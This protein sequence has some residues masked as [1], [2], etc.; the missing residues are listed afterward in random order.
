MATRCVNI[1]DNSFARTWVRPWL[2]WV[3]C[4]EDRLAV[5]AL[6]PRP[7][8]RRSARSVLS[9]SHDRVCSGSRGF[10]SFRSMG[11]A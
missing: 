5:L 7:W 6:K 10:V 2:P 9:R 1:T 3:V 8:G 11:W 4:S